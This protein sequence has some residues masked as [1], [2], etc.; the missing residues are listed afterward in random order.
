MKNIYSFILLFSWSVQSQQQLTGQIKI[1]ENATELSIEGVNLIWLNTSMGTI[2]VAYT[3]SAAGNVDSLTPSSNHTVTAG[4]YIK[5]TTNGAS[6]NTAR[7]Y[8]SVT[9]DRS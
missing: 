6:S 3:S 1:K 4:S 8:F 9:L 5:L 2:T 7:L